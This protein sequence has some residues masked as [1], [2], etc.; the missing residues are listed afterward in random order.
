MNTKKLAKF[1]P[2]LTAV[3]RLRLIHDAGKRG[4]AREQRRLLDAAPR[5]HFSRA[6]S[7]ELETRLTYAGIIQYAFQLG[8]AAEFW[9][10]QTRVAWANEGHENDVTGEPIPDADSFW[11]YSVV[12]LESLY[13]IDRDGWNLFLQQSGFDE[14]RITVPQ[15]AG[16]WMV[17]YMNENAKHHP[18]SLV[19][20]ALNWFLSRDANLR[21][22]RVD[23]LTLITPESVANCWHQVLE[24][25]TTV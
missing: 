6:D 11:I 24:E 21:A 1:Y 15:L 13:A 19:I 9:H 16:H 25:P 22:E 12:L 14:F 8:T 23:P 20:E 5:K 3:E 17:V 18:E 4:D 2:A 7:G 10:A